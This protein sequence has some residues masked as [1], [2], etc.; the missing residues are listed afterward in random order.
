MN[1][2]DNSTFD[3][4]NERSPN[5]VTHMD[6]LSMKKFKFQTSVDVFMQCKIRACAQQPC[7]VC[8]GNNPARSLSNVDLSPA[9][10]EMFAP[11]TQVK[12]GMNDHNALVFPDTQNTGS[13]GAGAAAPASSKPKG[14]TSKPIEIASQLTLT[15][16]TAS[17]AVEN[18]NALE[19][20]LRDTLSLR[21]DEEL[22]ITSISKIGRQLAEDETRKLQ[23]AQGVRIDFTVGVQDPARALQ[24]KTALKNLS[25]GNESVIRKFSQ[26]LDQELQQ[27]GKA[28]VNLPISSMSFAQPEQ[29][30]VQLWS[31][32]RA[33]SPQ[34]NN[35]G[36]NTAAYNPYGS[37]AQNPAQ[38]HTTVK[39]S[40]SSSTI[41]LAMGGIAIVG[42][43]FFLAY[44]KGKAASGQAGNGHMAHHGAHQMQAPVEDA[45]ASKVASMDADWMNQ[46]PEETGQANW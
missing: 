46:S 12:V 8:T 15:S 3:T 21:A 19:A 27:R 34:T 10:G 17:W 26:Q 42:L 18:R 30:E 31:N 11:P 22:V 40:S 2:C 41:L 16:I 1:Y 20:T 33:S 13:Y 6:R 45:Y 14:A 39:K 32:N 24:S 9:E 7:G 4:M 25:S 23:A 38:T 35:Y 29:R 37:Q 28:P 36:Q 43:L 44:N 5:G